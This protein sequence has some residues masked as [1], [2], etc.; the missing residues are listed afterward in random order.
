MNFFITKL[1]KGYLCAANVQWEKNGSCFPDELSGVSR[2]GGVS[3]ET[4]FL[5]IT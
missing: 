2:E 1:K 4:P 5:I 3:R